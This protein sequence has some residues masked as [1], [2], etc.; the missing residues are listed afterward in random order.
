MAPQYVRGFFLEK[1]YEYS[2]GDK[3]KNVIGS[4][5]AGRGCLAGP[6]ICASA[7]IKLD[8]KILDH[9][10][11][12]GVGDSK[13][14]SSRK[15]EALFYKIVGDTDLS[16]FYEDMSFSLRNKYFSV[17]VEGRGRAFIDKYNI[18]NASLDGMKE[19]FLG[20]NLSKKKDSLW[21]IDGNRKPVLEGVSCS[22]EALVKGDERSLSIGMASIFAKVFRD[23]YMLHLST[24]DSRYNFEK[25]K[26]Y[27]TSE[28]KNLIKEYGPSKFHRKTFKGVSEYL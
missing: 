8:K 16:S 17:K 13:K 22:V 12:I 20:F 18:L 2:I 14:L 19:T 24:L 1:K 6:V 21:I 27:P 5:E 11:S 26:G 15:R 25:H 3:Y 9:F 28:H 10:A 23:K 4:D 7:L